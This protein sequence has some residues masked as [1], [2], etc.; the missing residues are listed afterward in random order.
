MNLILITIDCLRA[1]RLSCLGYHKVTTPNLDFLASIGSVFT[2][3][4]SVSIRTQPSFKAIFTS[5]YPLMH[6]GQLCIA[7]SR[8]TLAQVLREHGY[9]TAAFHSNAFVSSYFGYNKGFDFFFDGSH[10]QHSV[11]FSRASKAFTDYIP[12]QRMAATIRRLHKLI[13]REYPYWKCLITSP[14]IIAGDLNK[15]LLS[16]I[17]AKRNSCFLWVHYMDAHE[18][19]IGSYRSIGPYGRLRAL[20]LNKRARQFPRSLSSDEIS[21][22]ISLYDARIKYVDDKIGDLLRILGQNGIL[23]NT[24]IVVT[25]DHGQQFMEHGFYA[26]SGFHPWDE[27]VR[28]PLIVVGPGVKHRVIGQQ[29]SLLNLAPTILDLVNIDNPNVFLGHSLQPLLTGSIDEA[30]DSDAYIEI[31]TTI[32]GT[33]TSHLENSQ[34]DVSRRVI[35]LR[36]DKWKY[37]FIEGMKDE[38]YDFVNDPKETRNVIDYHP[39]ISAELRAKILGHIQANRHSGEVE[40]LKTRIRNLRT[41]RDI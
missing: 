5:T 24:F 14:Y 23:E 35:A 28:V 34:L 38:L 37:I 36:T 41:R 31:D 27:L 13:T 8:T 33:E 39:D 18:P 32:S 15:E 29:V 19:Y 9:H 30:A 25:S 10:Y 26:H 6:K 20:V 4:I 7:K 17:P 40:F 21:W 2:Q 3:A 11:R 22:L 16:W 12:S 1:D